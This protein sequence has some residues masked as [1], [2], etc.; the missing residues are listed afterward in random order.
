MARAPE[1]LIVVLLCGLSH[2]NRRVPSFVLLPLSFFVYFLCLAH[3]LLILTTSVWGYS[4]FSAN[5][6]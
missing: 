2:S 1:I 4:Q 5:R 3:W 6:F